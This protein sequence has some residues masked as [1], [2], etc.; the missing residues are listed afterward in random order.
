MD[1][2]EAIEEAIKWRSCV[3]AIGDGADDVSQAIRDQVW[4]A[5]HRLE[6]LASL[7]EAAMEHCE[8]VQRLD[9]IREVPHLG[10]EF[11]E[12]SNKIDETYRRWL[13]LHKSV[14]VNNTSG[15]EWWHAK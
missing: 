3:R 15:K 5:N 12:A 13:K 2:R 9:Q 10:A 7:A 14:Q 11:V 4:D 1:L 6:Q 8:A